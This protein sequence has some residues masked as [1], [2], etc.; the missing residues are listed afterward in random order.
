MKETSIIF[1]GQSV[2]ATLEKLKK[3]TRRTAGLRQVNK[4]P[5][6]WELLGFAP[7]AGI[8]KFRNIIDSNILEIRCPYGVPGDKLWVKETFV[9]ENTFGYSNSV[10]LPTDR[11][12]KRMKDTDDDYYYLIPHY[13]ATEPE[14]H[15]VPDD[16]ENDWDDRTRWSSSL[17]MPKWV[18]RIWL[19]ITGV[20]LERVQDMT[21]LDA[22]D[23][24]CPAISCDE[25]MSE[26]LEW[27]E[28]LWNSL[29][30]KRGY[31]WDVNPWVWVILFKLL[32]CSGRQ[33]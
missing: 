2:R 7:E 20:R 16:R 25:D 17:F 5:N 33:K 26:V 31:G 4:N 30:V 10:I 29:N 13:R 3:Q 28:D 12:F 1:L 15:I 11:P 23:E 27:Y 14:P 8:A 18:T 24:G 9:L 22:I 32:S 6:D 21:E 19:E